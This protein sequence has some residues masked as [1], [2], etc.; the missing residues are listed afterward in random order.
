MK[1]IFG[2]AM[3]HLITQSDGMSKAVLFILLGMSMLCWTI[4]LYKIILLRIKKMQL[5]RAR[6]YIKNITSFDDMLAGTALFAGTLPGYFLSNSLAL[7]KKLLSKKQEGVQSRLSK[8]EQQLL[9]YAVDHMVDDMV[10]QEESYISVLSASAAISPLLGLFG[11]VWGLVVSFIAISQKQN[12]DISTVAPGIAE[13]LITTLAGLMVAIPAL[14]MVYY[15]NGQ[16]RSLE[17]GMYAIADRFIWHVHHLFGQE[18][19]E[20][21]EKIEAASVDATSTEQGDEAWGE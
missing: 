21:D 10:A 8:R 13:A 4:L 16:V 9:D 19:V 17:Q 18:I 12:A 2:N 5:K 7:L 1:F 11:T 14:A 6:D 15:L 3:W 20:E